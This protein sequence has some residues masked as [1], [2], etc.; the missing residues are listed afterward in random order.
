VVGRAGL[1]ISRRRAR[2]VHAGKPQIS[3]SKRQEKSQILNHQNNVR[4]LEILG[5]GFPWDL[6]S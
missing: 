4:P 2:Y 1:G 3:S 5:L 6:V